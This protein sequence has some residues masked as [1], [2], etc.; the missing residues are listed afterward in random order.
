MRVKGGVAAL[1][2]IVALSAAVLVSCKK[3]VFFDTRVAD[4]ENPR[5]QKKMPRTSADLFEP[6]IVT[7]EDLPNPDRGGAFDDWAT[8]LI[9]V[10]EGH[11]HGGGKM[12]GN[13]VYPGVPWRQEEFVVV[14]NRPSGVR[15]EVDRSSTVTRR[16]S[17]Q[18]K[19]GPNYI[20][21]IGGGS[22]LWGFC[23]YFYDRQGRL[24]ND[25][26]LAHSDEYQVF[27]SISDVDDQGRAY[28]VLDVRYRGT[29]EGEQPVAAAFFED[30]KSFEARRLATPAILHY[31]YRDTWRHEDM[32]DG[33]RQ[34]FNIRLLPPFS[35]YDYEDARA[36]DV[37]CVG[38]KGHFSFV[39]WGEVPIDAAEWPVKLT[40]GYSYG[41]YGSR[42]TGLLPQFN[43]AVRVMKCPKGKK[44]VVPFTGSDGHT[45]HACAPYYAPQ[46]QSGW[47]E[48]VRMNIPIKVYTNA[49]ESDPTRPDPNEPY[50]YHL[51][52][53][54][55]MSAQ[56]AYEAIGDL[57]VHGTTGAGGLGFGAWFL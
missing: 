7:D 46:E 44:L 15:V 30:K 20:R 16:E 5:L 57:M 25:D 13:F 11:P 53:E 37:D 3:F 17:E 48:L 51:G 33:V 27:F 39:N 18:G 24:L 14:H 40:N 4:E 32:A 43:L 35:R 50:C 23:F 47:R 54:I 8:C 36:E 26:I 29:G 28:D 31:T 42:R 52:R 55:G 56:E 49:Y 22:K 41:L 45:R 34:F 9:M 12:H 10:K 2:V 38:L 21:I 6:P 19:E 1:W